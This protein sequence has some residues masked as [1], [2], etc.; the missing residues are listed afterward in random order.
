MLLCMPMEMIMD[1]P[2]LKGIKVKNKAFRQKERTG[3][4]EHFLNS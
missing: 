4:D 1:G 3:F 2:N